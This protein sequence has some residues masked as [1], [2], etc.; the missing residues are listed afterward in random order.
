MTDL[1][2][3]ITAA[4][5][6]RQAYRDRIDNV[7]D[8]WSELARGAHTLASAFTDASARI[9][10]LE[11]RAAEGLTA[12][13]KTP[14]DWGGSELN[15]AIAELTPS[16]DEVRARFHRTTVNIGVVGQAAAGKSTLLRTITR[17]QRGGHPL[18][19]VQVDDGGSQ[20]DPAF[21]RPG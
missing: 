10:R 8:A 19:R 14:S 16:F 1:G 15:R 2:G 20:P 3:Q 6:S 4:L 13:D 9:A 11:Q 18:G 17:A 21:A 5:G 7:Y 12:D